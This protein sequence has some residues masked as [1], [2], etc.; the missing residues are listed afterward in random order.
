M[1]DATL[2]IDDATED[3]LLATLDIEEATDD[4]EEAAEELPSDEREAAEDAAPDAEDAASLAEEAISE[5]EEEAALA[6][7]EFWPKAML[8]NPSSNSR[9]ARVAITAILR[10]ICSHGKVQGQAGAKGRRASGPGSSDSTC[11]SSRLYAA[12]CSLV[13]PKRG[14]CSAGSAV[15]IRAAKPTCR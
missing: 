11:S 12:S 10:E 9:C 7:E 13:R 5:A 6:A 8:L 2:D 4:S 3:K 14:I 15:E 1:V